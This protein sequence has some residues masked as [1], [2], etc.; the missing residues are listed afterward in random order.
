MKAF[1]LPIGDASC[2]QEDLII[3]REFV[4]I[5]LVEDDPIIPGRYY[6]A[7]FPDIRISGDLLT[8]LGIKI[9]GIVE[10]ET[11]NDE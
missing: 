2:V 3:C 7:D 5:R 6:A 11:Y 10:Q 9:V 8:R 4:T 1:L